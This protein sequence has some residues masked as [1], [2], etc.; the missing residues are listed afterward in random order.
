MA[1]FSKLFGKQEEV[2]SEVMIGA[3]L[4]GTLI[5]LSEVPDQVFSSGVLGLGCGI[6][7]NSNEVV[8]PCDGIITMV[9]ETKHAI[10]MTAKNGAEFL[11][12]VG[13]DTVDMEGEG[14]TIEVEENQ[15]V[16]KGQLLMTFDP[17]VIASADHPKTTVFI[18][19]NHDELSSV[20]FEDGKVVSLGDEIGVVTK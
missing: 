3:P 19:T 20:N 4:S 12:H 7:P 5:T 11:I 9:A 8:A 2:S 1:L 18:V 16:T 10:G 15:K 17:V 13:I 6:E 14:F